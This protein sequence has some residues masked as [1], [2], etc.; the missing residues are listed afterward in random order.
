MMGADG[1]QALEDER[2][3]HRVW[4]DSFSIDLYEVTTAQY[5][6]F[7]AASKRPLPW[8]SETV[9]LTQH[10]D[11][12]VVGVDWRDADAY[13]ASSGKR[14]PTE[15]EWEKAA[16]GPDGNLFPWGESA[17]DSRRAMFG[18][19]HVHEIPILSSVDSHLEGESPYGLRHMAGNVAEW[20]Q[21]W[22]GF[23]Y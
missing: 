20:T 1:T 17:P 21:D 6:A 2:P 14:L 5:A 19:H 15:A 18:Q 11:R 4:L 3:A 13:C 7:L 10:G 22:F 9:D 8:Q 23:D 12:P 16:R